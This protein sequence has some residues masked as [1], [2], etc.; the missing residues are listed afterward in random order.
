LNEKINLPQA[1]INYFVLARWNLQQE[2]LEIY[3]EKELKAKRIKQMKFTINQNASFK[4][5]S[6]SFG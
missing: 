2:R 6:L 3:F 1:Y 4:R 5:G